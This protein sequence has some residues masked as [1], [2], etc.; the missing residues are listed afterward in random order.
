[1]ICDGI[2]KVYKSKRAYKHSRSYQNFN[3]YYTS[4]NKVK[5]HCTIN[6]T[7]IY[8]D[9]LQKTSSVIKKTIAFNKTP[10]SLEIQFKSNL[11][12]LIFGISME[13]SNGVV[14]DNIPLRGASGTEFAKINYVSLKQ[15]HQLLSPDLFILEFGG[16]AIPYIK[17]EERAN[18][19][20]NYFKRQI[21]KLKKI[22]PN[23][24]VL[25]IGPGDMAKKENTDLVSYP[26]IEQVRDA[27]RK[28][29]FETNSCFWDMYLNM[30]GENSIISWSK[31]T[32]SLA[33]RDYIHFTNAGARKI[34]D[35]FIEDLLMDYNNYLMLKNEK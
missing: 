4:E 21:Q 12:P 35:M 17:S 28:A 14:V 31:E 8:E 23:A 16:N 10:N 27:L 18:S 30:G 19:Y 34:A 9:S 2:L 11:S 25:V 20:G 26:F 33:A 22:N 3:F 5:I 32:P 29:A 24:I 1:M 13:G 7:I 6:D 15:M